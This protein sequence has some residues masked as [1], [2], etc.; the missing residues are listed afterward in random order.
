MK[1]SLKATAVLVAAAA[2]VGSV[3]LPAQAVGVAAQTCPGGSVVGHSS[4]RGGADT[5]ATGCKD[6]LKVAVRQHYTATGGKAYITKW[7][8]SGN[9]VLTIKQANPGYP[10][11][12]A[13][14]YYV[15]GVAGQKP[16]FSQ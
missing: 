14:H 5:N 1:F 10:V 16:I 2:L 9:Y 11:F 12:Q 7:K 4:A 3:S 13:D 8:I 6:A 15:A